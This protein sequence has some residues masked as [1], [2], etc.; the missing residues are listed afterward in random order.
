[1]IRELGN[2]ELFE[3][4]ETIPKVQ[5]S[6][7]LLCWNQGIVYCTCGQ[8]WIYSESRRTFN[9]LRLDAI[10][11][12]DYVIKKRATHGARH[13]KTEEQKKYHVA[14]NARKRCCKKVDFQGGHLQVFTIDFSEIQ[15]IVNHN[16][17]SDGP[18][19]SAKRWTK[20]QSKITRIISLSLSR[21][22]EK[23]PRTMVSHL[24][25]VRQKWATRLRP[26]FRAAVSLKN[27]LLRE[28]GEQVAERISPK[29][30]RRWHPSASTSWWDKS[31]WNWKWAHKN[32]SSDLF[33]TVGFVYSR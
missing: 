25:W 24:E 1:M 33:V 4:C 23:I 2:V 18:S 32:F 14:W 16:S 19:K 22:K 31:E 13:G 20:W 21:G 10:C 30:Y 9:R 29:Q 27:R 26:D 15:F 3:L 7:C 5:C 17:Q 6:H 11:I 8:C 12:P 28:S